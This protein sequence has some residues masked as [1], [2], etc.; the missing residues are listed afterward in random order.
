MFRTTVDRNGRVVLPR[1][2]PIPAAG[3]SF[4]SFRQDVD[5]MVHRAYVASTASVAIGRVRQISVLSIRRSQCSGSAPRHRS[6]FRGRC[7]LA[8]GRYQENR[9][10]AKCPRPARW[11]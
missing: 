11:P 9:L 6:F 8:V 3:R 7:D 5:A 10:A 2:A 1:M 4:G